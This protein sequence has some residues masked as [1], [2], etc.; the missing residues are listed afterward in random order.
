MVTPTPQPTA[1][2]LA[3]PTAAELTAGDDPG[4]YRRL[5]SLTLLRIALVTFLLG[6]SAFV[7]LR[8]DVQDLGRVETVLYG[9]IIGTYLASLANLLVLRRS[10]QLHRLLAFAQIVGDVFICSALVYL[11][12]GAE[13]V[14]VFMFPLTV[15]SAAVL[16]YRQGAIVASTLSCVGLSLVVVGLNA[17]W[18]PPASPIL[19][20]AELP[21]PRL[22]YFLFGNASANFLT[23]ALASY[24][25]EQLRSTGE[26]LR[27]ATD[28]YKTLELL[29]ENI[30]RSI[31]SGICATDRF[32][33]ITFLNRAGE[34]I[35]GLSLDAVQR[36]PIEKQL[37]WLAGRLHGDLPIDRF[38]AVHP[39]GGAQSTLSISVAPLVDREGGRQGYVVAFQDLTSIRA[40]E[41]AVKRSERL[42]AVGA[43]AAGLAHEL[44]NPL[45]SMGG[46]LQLLGDSKTFSGDEERLM[47]IVLREAD[48]L[49]GL[50]T[51]FLQFARPS[52]PMLHPMDLRLV[53][54]ETLTLFRND[55][56]RRGVAIEEQLEGALPVRADP[57]Q[58]RQVL[59]NLLKNAAE[60]MPAGGKVSV[61]AFVKGGT[62]AVQVV[63]SGAGID[64]AE[65]P[66]IFD[67]FFTTKAGGTGLGL[68]TVHGIVVGH[69]GHIE[70]GSEAGKGTTF[71]VCLPLHQLARAAS[72]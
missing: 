67:P 13:S 21:L 23:A 15:V 42:A 39:H 26:R 43:M 8:A 16:L 65:L 72:A 69:G 56:A 55:P 5:V 66:R 57:G 28:D 48:R 9:V 53:I 27:V 14:L 10:Q 37:P 51:D 1:P 4:L 60:S 18:L 11:T 61:R 36:A 2:Q 6:A 38:E 64:A 29:H 49:N 45:A 32:G 7:V 41:E 46:S 35:T 71:T 30:V 22:L 34:E 63:D 62:V 58:V 19:A 47:R 17:G 20:P 68:A 24:L 3:Q 54:E 25:A 50:V 52:P 70:V 12:S 44:R 40:M 31:N 59:W 33:R